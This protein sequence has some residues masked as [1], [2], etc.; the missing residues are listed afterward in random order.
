MPLFYFFFFLSS[1]RMGKILL[2]SFW[3]FGGFFSTTLSA[4]DRFVDR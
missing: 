2:V 1:R 4:L 3:V